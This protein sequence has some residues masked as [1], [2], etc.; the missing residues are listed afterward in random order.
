MSQKFNLLQEKIPTIFQQTWTYRDARHSIELPL[1]ISFGELEN[2]QTG[3]HF[4]SSKAPGGKKYVQLSTMV[5]DL[6]ECDARVRYDHL[7]VKTTEGDKK[8]TELM[9]LCCPKPLKAKK[10]EDKQ[11]DECAARKRKRSKTESKGAAP[12]AV[13]EPA[14]KKARQNKAKQQSNANDA[15]AATGHG[16]FGN[17]AVLAGQDKE[18][19]ENFNKFESINMELESKSK[20]FFA[21]WSHNVAHQWKYN[22]I[23][24]NFAGIVKG[25]MERVEE[26]MKALRARVDVLEKATK[27]SKPEP[28]RPK[29]VLPASETKTAPTLN[30]KRPRKPKKS[31]SEDDSVSSSDY[32][33]DDD[34][35]DLILPVAAKRASRCREPGALAEKAGALRDLPSEDSDDSDVNSGSLATPEASE[36]ESSNAEDANSG[37]DSSSGE[38]VPPPAVTQK[39]AKQPSRSLKLKEP[40]AKKRDGAEEQTPAFL[41]DAEMPDVLKLPKLEKEK[42]VNPKVTKEKKTVPAGSDGKAKPVAKTGIVTNQGIKTVPLAVANKLQKPKPQKPAPQPKPSME[43]KIEKQAASKGEKTFAA[44]TEEQEKSDKDRLIASLYNEVNQISAQAGLRT[45][46]DDF[47]NPEEEEYDEY[48]DLNN[49]E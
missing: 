27:A 23:V 25:N 31:P 13:Q 20:E 35:K 33:G 16:M 42:K 9:D 32:S 29:K 41:V 10:P 3:W 5:K 38:F 47:E 19:A 39:P 49:L 8:F 12:E 43:K 26:E 48:D 1:K 44:R 45:I 2:G 17:L 11:G 21:A 46:D 14:P 34:P 30:S 24:N 7:F 40:A 36:Q 15:H 37:E 4:C 28:V 18:F 6:Y 22:Q